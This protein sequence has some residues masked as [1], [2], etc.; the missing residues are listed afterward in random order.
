MTPNMLYSTLF[1]FSKRV[2][3]KEAKFC[4][5][6]VRNHDRFI[7]TLIVVNIDIE[8]VRIR[9]RDVDIVRNCEV[10]IDMVHT[11]WLSYPNTLNININ[12]N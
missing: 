10:Q 12:Y 4:K 2:G 3:G 6:R 9:H 8:S 7:I 5:R 11:H 1:S